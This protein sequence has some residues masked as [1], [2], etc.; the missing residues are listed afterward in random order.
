MINLMATMFG[1][2]CN[3]GDMCKIWG[4]K[5]EGVQHKG[6]GQWASHDERLGNNNRGGRSLHLEIVFVYNV[7]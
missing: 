2:M 6:R 5:R 7:V 4:L 3:N 1:D